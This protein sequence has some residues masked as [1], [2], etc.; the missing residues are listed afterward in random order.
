MAGPSV[1]LLHE[2]EQP[3]SYW[4]ELAARLYKRCWM[5]WKGMKVYPMSADAMCVVVPY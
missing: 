1:F 2:K 4:V 5:I 3:A